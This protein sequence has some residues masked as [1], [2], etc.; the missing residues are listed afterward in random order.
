MRQLSSVQ[1]FCAD[2]SL[3]RSFFYKLCQ[4]GKGPRLTK[5]GARTLVSMEAAAEWRARMEAASS[6]GV[7]Q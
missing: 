7:A 6:Q 1:Q 5:L 4:Q 3:S 2:H